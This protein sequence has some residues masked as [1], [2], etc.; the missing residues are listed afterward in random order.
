MTAA[1]LATALSVAN[2]TSADLETRIA[3]TVAGMK[4][5]L[6]AIVAAEGGPSGFGP[7]YQR[8]VTRGMCLRH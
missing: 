4:A 5:A 3:A 6:D 2:A 7:Q 8:C 1:L